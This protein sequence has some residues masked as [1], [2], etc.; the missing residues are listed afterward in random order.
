[1]SIP[2]DYDIAIIGDGITGLSAAFHLQKL[3]FS[4]LCLFGKDRGSPGGIKPPP[5][6]TAFILGGLAD[7]F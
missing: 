2:L 7:N 6:S 3:G 1:M 4:R 5:R